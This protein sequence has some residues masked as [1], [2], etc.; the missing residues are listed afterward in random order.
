MKKFL[1]ITSYPSGVGQLAKKVAEKYGCQTEITDHNDGLVK[2]LELQ[3]DYV[4]IGDAEY[5]KGAGEKNTIGCQTYQDITRSA[6]P[7]QIIRQVGWGKTD[8]ANY[9]RLPFSPED[10]AKSFGL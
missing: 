9:L 4:V 1:I 6:S 2:F 5:I 3:P 7:N 10:F 8:Q